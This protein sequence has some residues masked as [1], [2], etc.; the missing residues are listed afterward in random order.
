LNTP[1]FQTY[2]FVNQ[3]KSMEICDYLNDLFEA[4][5]WYLE[6]TSHLLDYHEIFLFRMVR[7][8]AGLFED[9]AKKGEDIKR[10]LN[11]IIIMQIKKIM[12]KIMFFFDPEINFK[13]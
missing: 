1:E 8:I 12:A 3:R 10:V 13:E 2:M 9:K 5:F 11:E 4:S 6:E 7:I